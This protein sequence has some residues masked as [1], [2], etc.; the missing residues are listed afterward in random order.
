MRAPL[1]ALFLFALILSAGPAAAQSSLDGIERTITDLGRANSLYLD[2]SMERQ[3]FQFD[4][5]Q[6]RLRRSI[7][8]PP[9]VIVV[10]DT[11]LRR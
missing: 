5:N 3:Q 8:A 2:R 1:A 9:T 10:P 6:L 7:E 4:I 11:R